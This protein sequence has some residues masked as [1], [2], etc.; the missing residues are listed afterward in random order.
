MRDH[1]VP[2]RE[3]RLDLIA[4]ALKGAS[5]GGTQFRCLYRW[6]N[7]WGSRRYS[8]MMRRLKCRPHSGQICS[9]P[10]PVRSYSQWI[11]NGSLRAGM[12]CLALNRP[13]K[14]GLSA[15]EHDL[16]AEPAV[17]FEGAED[18]RF[19]AGPASSFVADADPKS[20]IDLAARGG[21]S[22]QTAARQLGSWRETS[23]TDRAD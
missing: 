5:A 14:S 7:Q 23:L 4:P 8:S 21:A 16:G 10:R 22:W 2:S 11:Q 20:F 12:T 17:A 3:R 1:H 9:S 6:I 19:A 15:V 18:D 13:Q